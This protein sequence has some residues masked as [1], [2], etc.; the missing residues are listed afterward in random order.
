MVQANTIPALVQALEGADARMHAADA[1]AS[2]AKN[3]L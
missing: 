3:S 1:L 2:L